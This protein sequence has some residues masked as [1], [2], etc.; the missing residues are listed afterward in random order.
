MKARE[1]RELF[2]S[3]SVKELRLRAVQVAEELLKRRCR[4]AIG[5]AVGLESPTTARRR[6][7]RIQTELRSRVAG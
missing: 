5:Q 3:L 6:L 4:A 7:A 1:E 2:K